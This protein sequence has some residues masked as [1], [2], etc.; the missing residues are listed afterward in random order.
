MNFEHTNWFRGITVV[1]A[2]ASAWWLC[3]LVGLWPF[4]HRAAAVVAVFALCLAGAQRLITMLLGVLLLLVLP[5]RG[6]QR[7]PEGA[8]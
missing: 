7:Q 5:N 1:L 2:L 4:G 3:S 8:Q 6:A